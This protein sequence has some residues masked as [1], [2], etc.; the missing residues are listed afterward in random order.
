MALTTLADWR[1]HMLSAHNG[2][3]ENDDLEG[4]QESHA[5]EVAHHGPCDLS[6]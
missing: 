4:I 5:L 1:E 2:Y 6:S 3:G